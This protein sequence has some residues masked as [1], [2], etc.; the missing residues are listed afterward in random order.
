MAIRVTTML[1]QEMTRKEFLSF[2]GMVFGLLILKNLPFGETAQSRAAH[3]PGSY[4]NAPY[5]GT[6]KS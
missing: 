3:S 1:H 2:V 5:G 6:K 4:G